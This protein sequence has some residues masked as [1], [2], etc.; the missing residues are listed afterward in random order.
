MIKGPKK[1]GKSYLL[2]Q[3][4]KFLDN[5]NIFAKYIE[6]Y[7]D[8]VKFITEIKTQVKTGKKTVYLIDN[9][10]N[11]PLGQCEKLRN[12]LNNFSNLNLIVSGRGSLDKYFIDYKSPFYK[13]FKSIALEVWSKETIERFFSVLLP[14]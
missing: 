2:K 6:D 4:K 5:K 8:P 13:M 10:H 12:I 1:I 9:F 7:D 14:G 3:I 11:Y